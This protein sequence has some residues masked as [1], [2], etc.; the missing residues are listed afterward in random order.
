M[1]AL[2]RKPEQILAERFDGT[3]ESA[4]KII[5]WMKSFEEEGV[6]YYHLQLKEERLALGTDDSATVNDV[7]ELTISTKKA[8]YFL[9]PGNWMVLSEEEGF[10][11][12]Y[13]DFLAKHYDEI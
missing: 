8:R 11:T 3:P 13:D 7:P 2:K 6:T 10:K 12:S 1:K 4:K 5:D 9:T